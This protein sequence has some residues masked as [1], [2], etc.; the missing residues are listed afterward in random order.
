MRSEEK[1]DFK[2]SCL[3]CSDVC[4]VAIEKKKKVNMR[5]NIW[6]VRVLHLKEKISDFAKERNDEIGD[7]IFKR[8]NSVLCLVAEEARYHE[9]CYSTFFSNKP[10]SLKRGRPKDK[11]MDC[12]F[13]NLCRYI[14]EAEECQFTL[15]EL[16]KISEEN[17]AESSS[18]TEKT[19]KNKLMHVYGDG[20]MFFQMHKRSPLVCF[21]GSELK[22][23]NSWY[24]DREKTEKDERLRI[25]KAAATIIHQ[26]IR[27][28]PYNTTNYPDVTE[29]MKDADDA[30]PE[31]LHTFLQLIQKNKKG[32]KEKVEK[33]CTAIAHAIIAATR[34]RSF[35]SSL[36]LGLSEYLFR[37]TGSKTIVNA[38]SSFGFCSNYNDISLFEAS[39][40]MSWK[41]DVGKDA[42]CQYV[43][44]NADFNIQTLS[45][46]GTF[47][48]MGGIKC[49]TH[50]F[51]FL[52]LE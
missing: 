39:A 34:P 38:V 21:R 29:I 40:A 26:D 10:S 48:S 17:M 33:K 36:L 20:V 19:L 15:K 7:K 28:T 37:K 24:T 32:D 12:A 4:D 46:K 14:D 51:I 1:F 49:I 3:F 31:T 23:V 8:V 30:V 13:E 2:N 18:V 47:H 43:F 5:R 45:G 6:E 11:N 16:M 41:P 22:L 27:T 42:F 44:D 25:V 35:M 52:Y 50:S 9:N